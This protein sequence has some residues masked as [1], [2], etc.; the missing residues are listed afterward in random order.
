MQLQ[1]H[2]LPPK[3]SLVSLPALHSLL[4]RLGFLVFFLMFLEHVR[5][6]LVAPL[7]LSSL[8][9]KLCEYRDIVLFTV[10]LLACGRYS[11]NSHCMNG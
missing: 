10:V 2:G 11:M 4:A 3:S 9:Y 6:F 8:E 7:F 1:A 5:L